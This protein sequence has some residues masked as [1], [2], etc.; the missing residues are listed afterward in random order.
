MSY[1]LDFGLVV[2]V[3]REVLEHCGLRCFHCDDCV[4]GCLFVYLDIRCECSGI[5]V[6][7]WVFI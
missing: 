6:W 1:L 3:T 7:S 5:V 2:T 4:I